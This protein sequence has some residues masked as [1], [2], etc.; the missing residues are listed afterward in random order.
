LIFLSIIFAKD[1]DEAGVGKRIAE[2]ARKYGV[3]NLNVLFLTPLPGTRLWDQMKSQDRIAL[4]TF[5]QDW[6]YYTLTFPVARYKHLSL[7]SIIEEM[8]SCDRDFYSM[9][10]ILRR[11]LGN[12]WH[13]RQPLISLVGN[14]SYRS[15]LRLNGKA[16]AHFKSYLHPY[17][18]PSDSLTKR[19]IAIERNDCI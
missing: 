10:R 18:S 8:I 16:Y 4:D 2:E 11:T 9:P 13:R 12:L 19:Q 7:D 3:D 1:I 5:P 6:K 17:R 15:N 14:L